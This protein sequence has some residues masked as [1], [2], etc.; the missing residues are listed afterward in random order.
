LTRSWSILAEAGT[1]AEFYTAWLDLLCSELGEVT[2]ALLLLQGD[3]DAYLPAAV[4]PQPVSDVS[5]LSEPA[6][7]AIVSA[8]PSFVF[9][10]EPVRGKTQVIVAHPI[11]CDSVVRGV[12]VVDLRLSTREESIAVSHRIG[13]A[14]G[15]PEAM[16]RRQQLGSRARKVDRLSLLRCTNGAADAHAYFDASAISLANEIVRQFSAERVSI[17]MDSRRGLKIAAIS[18]SVSHDRRSTLIRD[19]EAAM[20]EAFDQYGPVSHPES[21]A[22]ARRIS[23]AHAFYCERWSVGAVLSVLIVSAAA[24]VGVL[25]IERRA[26]ERFEYPDVEAAV[27]VARCIGP[28]LDLKYQKDRLLLGR[29]LR[30]LQSGTGALFDRNRPSIKLATALAVLAAVGLAAWPA[31]F[32]VSARALLEGQSQRVVAAPFD[33]FVDEAPVRAGDRVSAGQVIA[34][35]DDRDL[36]LE[37]RKWEYEEQKLILRQREAA[38][39]H[40]RANVAIIGA[41]ID[42]ARGQLAL[43]R[44]KIKRTRL[45]SPIDG[46]V[47]SGD[48]SQKRGAPVSQGKV[49]FEVAPDSAY[50]LI[51]AI[52]ERDVGLVAAGQRGSLV[53]TGLPANPISLSVTR[54]LAVASVEDGRNVFKIEA[55][56]EGSPATLRPGM[57]GVA[58]V[59]VGER[60]LLSIWMRPVIDRLTV[61]AWAWLP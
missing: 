49:L 15:W 2:R 39:K 24:P 6:H 35:L 4:W 27:E 11:K 33:G 53:L 30:V 44:E 56:I 22:T 23:V 58:K 21:N 46:F 36:Q 14:S 18:H 60:S 45:A 9:G 25:T 8:M 16:Y 54:P 32:R 5:G 7:H 40:E 48:L 17:A 31:E 41:Q 43:V 29:G 61:L 52:D 19:L 59:V 42:Q 26:G 57:E 20:Q 37:R 55:S 3:D 50:R 10:D 34:T 12:V 13:Q 51:L 38:A 28:I 47:V 1:T